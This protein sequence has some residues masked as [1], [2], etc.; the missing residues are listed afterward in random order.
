MDAQERPAEGNKMLCLATLAAHAQKAVLKPTEF[1]VVLEFLFD[2]TR[3]IGLLRFEV[4]LECRV[5]FVNDLIK[6]GLL[7]AM[8]HVNRRA[9]AQPGLPANG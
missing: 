5:I 4:L 8:A 1:E 9:N 7:R 2:I 6:K 3:Q